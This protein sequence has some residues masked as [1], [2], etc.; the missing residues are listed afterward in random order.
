MKQTKNNVAKR[1]EDET[2]IKLSK[3]TKEELMYS[4]PVY[5]EKQLK[6]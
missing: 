1:L 2:P 6:I 4:L 5:S 3:T